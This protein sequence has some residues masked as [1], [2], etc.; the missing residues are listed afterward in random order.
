MFEILL[1]K[2]LRREL[3][4]ALFVG[5]V[6]WLFG[7]FVK[8]PQGLLTTSHFPRLDDY[9]ELCAD[10]F[11]RDVS[12]ALAYRISVPMLAWVLQL[13]PITCAFLPILFLISS[14]AVVFHIVS[15]RSGDKR[16]A[17]L[18]VAGLALTFFAVLTNRWLGCPDSFSHLFSA[19]ALFSSNPFLLAL[20]C[21]I[22]TLNDERW[23]MSVPLL[24]YWHGSNQSKAGIVNWTNAMRAGIGLAAGILVVILV[25]HALTV[26]WLGPGIVDS[27][28]SKMRAI[29]PDRLIPYNSTWA[30]FALNLFMGLGWYWL[31]V[32]KLVTRQ[33]ASAA[34]IWGYFL[35]FLVLIAS[36]STGLVEDVSKS[37]GFLYLAVVAASVRDYD[38]ASSSARIWWRNLLL[39]SYGDPNYLLYR[40]FRRS[41]YPI[42]DRLYRSPHASVCGR[43]LA[44]NSEALVS[45]SLVVGTRPN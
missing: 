41:F 45:S 36:F 15:D 5:T 24:L 17:L 6:I 4:L 44:A 8:F 26:G 3:P 23:I 18:V 34:P 2:F 38:A 22:G 20:C 35:S 29:P 1:S 31:T 12:P 32:I 13:P 28:Y 40:F 11:A 14:Y 16:F 10:P 27:W 9:L 21:V 37:I 7:I 42:S 19:L 30:L 33:L 39:A 25:R 43:R